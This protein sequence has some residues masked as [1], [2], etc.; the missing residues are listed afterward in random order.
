MGQV[1]DAGGG[2]SQ[3]VLTHPASGGGGMGA[4]TGCRHGH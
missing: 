3:K 1:A 4:K 2:G